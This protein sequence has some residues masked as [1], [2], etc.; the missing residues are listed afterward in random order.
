MMSFMA[1]ICTVSIK[2]LRNTNLV[3]CSSWSEAATR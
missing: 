2:V 1:E 3:S